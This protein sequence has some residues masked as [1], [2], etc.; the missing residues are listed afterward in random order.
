[1][2]LEVRELSVSFAKVRAVRNVDL[3]VAAG[4]VVGIIGPNGAGKTTLIDAICG[5]VRSTG[6]ITLEG[7][8]RLDHLPAYKRARAGVARTWQSI[9]LFD[10]LTVLDNVRIPRERLSVAS[11]V[12]NLLVGRR[13]APPKDALA[14]LDRLG[15][16]S[17]AERPASD[18]TP[19]Q[20]K[21]AG[22]ARAMASGA[23]IIFMDEPS[24]GLDSYETRPLGKQIRE[25][26]DSGIAVVLV[27][28]DMDLLFSVCDRVQVMATGQT[29]A[30]GTVDEVRR[31]PAVIEAYLGG[32]LADEA[33][34][35]GDS[36]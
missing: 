32:S 33:P 20:A 12:T 22:M 16:A 10:D 8:G 18:L 14:F 24:A 19:G 1:V 35:V 9:E 11:F 7:A 23:K 13:S 30:T 2:L 6:A 5:F 4:E 36:R 15:I 29:L 28:H 31:N 26:A 17:F 27:E 34:K 25:L 21:L 3:D